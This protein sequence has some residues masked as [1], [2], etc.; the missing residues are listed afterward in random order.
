MRLIKEFA[1]SSLVHVHRHDHDPHGHGHCDH[2]RQNCGFYFVYV[3]PANSIRMYV[4]YSSFS[5]AAI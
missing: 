5:L 1:L 3:V 2:R 4:V